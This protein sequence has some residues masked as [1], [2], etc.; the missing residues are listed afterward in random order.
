MKKPP[1]DLRE[2]LGATYNWV[3]MKV[4]REFN[5][6]FIHWPLKRKRVKKMKLKVKPKTRL[7]KHQEKRLERRGRHWCRRKDK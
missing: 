3:W 4:Y 6:T 5:W 2:Y 7:I 1:K